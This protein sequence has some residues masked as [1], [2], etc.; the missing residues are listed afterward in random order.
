MCLS[1]ILSSSIVYVN[2]EYLWWWV[3]RRDGWGLFVLQAR[4]PFF[5]V[6]R[7]RGGWLIN[8]SR[9]TI[10]IS[11]LWR[12]ILSK[13]LT[14]G[15]LEWHSGRNVGQWSVRAWKLWRYV[16][17]ICPYCFAFTNCH[18]YL[19]NHAFGPLVTSNGYG[20][21]N[22][23]KE[24]NDEEGNMMEILFLS[25]MSLWSFRRQQEHQQ[26]RNVSCF[27]LEVGLHVCM[28]RA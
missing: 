16:E 15:R 12:Q 2:A 20:N 25:L 5:P 22:H 17:D 8:Q 19:L 13:C 18:R 6:T 23:N 28:Y 7:E 24:D 10:H 26:R 1:V 21:N 11:C 14:S 4:W 3:L 9:M 27:L